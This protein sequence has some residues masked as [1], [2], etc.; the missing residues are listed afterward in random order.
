[1]KS[2]Q[3]G[4]RVFVVGE[5]RPIFTSTPIVWV[6]DRNGYT[7]TGL[8]RQTVCLVPEGHVG[9]PCSACGLRT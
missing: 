1:M 9:Q 4:D 3:V 2:I 7:N 5:T 8:P 6:I